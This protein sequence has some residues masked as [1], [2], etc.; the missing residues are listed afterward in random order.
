MDNEQLS[1]LWD[2]ISTAI[3]RIVK[4]VEK[5][6]EWQQDREF[7]EWLDNALDYSEGRAAALIDP[8]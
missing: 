7:S 3:R 8:S 5:L 6:P 4:R 2:S 1:E